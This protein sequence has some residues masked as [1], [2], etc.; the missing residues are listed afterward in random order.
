[1]KIGDWIKCEWLSGGIVL[2]YQTG[3]IVC[4]MPD[5][6]KIEVIDY[7]LTKASY[8]WLLRDRNCRYTPLTE[9]EIDD[10]KI[11]LL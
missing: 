4:F 2:L 1:M 5:Y 6:F 11:K 10:L 7:N 8:E 3:P 9:N